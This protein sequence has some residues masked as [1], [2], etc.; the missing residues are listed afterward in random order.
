MLALGSPHRWAACA[1]LHL[2]LLPVIEQDQLL[3]LFNLTERL[4]LSSLC[5][6][7]SGPGRAGKIAGM[8]WDDGHKSFEDKIM[9]TVQQ[10][11]CGEGV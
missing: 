1:T 3:H 6:A 8:T 10:G 7:T 5:I 11:G 9:D 4:S 2:T